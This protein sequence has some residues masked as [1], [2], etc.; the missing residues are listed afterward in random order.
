MSYTRKTKLSIVP[1]AVVPNMDELN[2]VIAELTVTQRNKVVVE[3]RAFYHARSQAGLGF[4]AMGRHLTELQATLEPV[5]KWKAFLRL[6]PNVSQAT[7]YRMIWA[8]Q[9][10][11]RLLPKATREVAVREGYRITSWMREG[12]FAQD[13]QGAVAEVTKRLGPAPADDEA[14][15]GQWLRAVLTKKRELGKRTAVTMITIEAKENMF[16]RQV[17][18]MVSGMADPEREQFGRR[19]AGLIASLCHVAPRTIK[20]VPLPVAIAA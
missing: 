6:L 17:E 13:Y 20:A 16:L 3:T 5:K 2:T 11:E 19:V 9:N 7:A 8:Y 1:K 4:L 10:A 15:A 14:K 18:R 12:G